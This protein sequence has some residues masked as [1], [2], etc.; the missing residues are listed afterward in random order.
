MGLYPARKC[1]NQQTGC[2]RIPEVFSNW[3]A[4]QPPTRDHRQLPD[5]VSGAATEMQVELQEKV[6]Q[7]MMWK[8]SKYQ[9]GEFLLCYLLRHLHISNSLHMFSL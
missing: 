8:Y 9:K 5:M 1:P 4:K 6:P 7:T 3:D 2:I